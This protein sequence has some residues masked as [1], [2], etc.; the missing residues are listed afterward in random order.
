MR[1]SMLDPKG[2]GGQGVRIRETILAREAGIRQEMST[3]GA[4]NSTCY[5]LLHDIRLTVGARGGELDKRWWPWGGDLDTAKTGL[6]NPPL[7]ATIDWCII[8]NS[9]IC[10]RSTAK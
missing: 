3:Q 9:V 2:E 4:G 1:Q 5:I 8:L 7:S 10:N 6:S